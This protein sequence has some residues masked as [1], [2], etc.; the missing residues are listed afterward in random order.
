MRKLLLT[1]F[2]TLV[3]ESSF[4]AQIIEVYDNIEVKIKA[5]STDVNRLHLVGDEVVE[6]HASKGDFSYSKSENT[7][8]LYFSIVSY[9]KNVN[10]FVETK[11]GYRYKFFLTVLNIPSEQII[12]NNPEIIS[13][14]DLVKNDS[15]KA[16]IANIFRSILKGYI[17]KG[18]KEN[19]ISK[20]YKH[21][22]QIKLKKTNYFTPL[23]SQNRYLAEKYFLIN[24]SNQEIS[25]EESQFFKKGVIAV[26]LK[27][28]TLLPGKVTQ[29]IIVK[30]S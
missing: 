25:L 9:K 28:K 13:N 1:I 6:V 30:G 22:D 16:E 11:K 7:G 15:Y 24:N 17:P 23:D 21:N 19:T 20:N 29:L 26:C 10:L 12:A 18:Y 2:L 14:S 8:D 3:A 4:A 27:A 5:S